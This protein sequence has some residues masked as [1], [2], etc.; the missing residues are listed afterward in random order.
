MFDRHLRRHEGDHLFRDPLARQTRYRKKSSVPR[1]LVDFADCDLW[2]SGKRP[3][4][5]CPEATTTW[6]RV[7]QGSI[8]SLS[9]L[10]TRG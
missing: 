3:A 10:E 6:P 2:M 5:I 9:A 4:A 1:S 8:E 7:I